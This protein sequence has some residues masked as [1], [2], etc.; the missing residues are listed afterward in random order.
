MCIRDRAIAAANNCA[1]QRATTL[2]NQAKKMLDNFMRNGCQC[3]GNNYVT[4]FY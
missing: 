1:N 4:N 3:S 2:Y